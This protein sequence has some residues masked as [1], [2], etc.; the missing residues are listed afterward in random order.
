MSQTNEPSPD[1]DRKYTEFGKAVW[2][3]MMSGDEMFNVPSLGASHALIR[4]AEETGLCQSA[5]Y[6]PER[7]GERPEIS[8]GELLWEIL[9]QPPENQA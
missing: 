4:M 9:V 6:D 8:E 3:W 1:S 7:H 2:A 5:V